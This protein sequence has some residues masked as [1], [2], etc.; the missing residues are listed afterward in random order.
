MRRKLA[1]NLKRL[2]ER[3]QNAC[4]RGKRRVEDVRL[5][6][7]TKT[8]EV[9]IIRSGIELG[10]SDLG[11]SRPQ[12]LVKRAGMVHEH[13]SRR[14]TLEPRRTPPDPRWHMIGH[15]QRNKVRMV[16]PWVGMIHSVDSLRLAEEVSSEAQR[17]GRVMPILIEVN[18]SGEK[19][20][21][22][23][24]VGAVSHLIENINT[25]P[26]I[27]IVG[28]MTM[29]PL[30][31][32]AES[33]R[34]YFCRLREILED[35]RGERLAG[36]EFRELSMGMSNDFEAAIEEGATLIRV[37]TALFEGVTQDHGAPAGT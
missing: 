14:R 28:L 12:E 26:G 3:I 22:G 24:A 17:I 5:V 31:E 10:L 1:D 8:V 34:P 32:K 2:R 19:S 13:L 25:L 11:E 4:S 21:F 37:G 33:A 18:V 27:R 23:I 35:V 36:P 7:V 16:L 6:A 15:L 9:D 30:E 29:A 20:K